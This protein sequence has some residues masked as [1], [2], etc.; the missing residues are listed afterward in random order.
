MKAVN[1]ELE[2]GICGMVHSFLSRVSSRFYEEENMVGREKCSK[3][4]LFVSKNVEEK[5]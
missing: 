3:M 4:R 2:V 1:L 5:C